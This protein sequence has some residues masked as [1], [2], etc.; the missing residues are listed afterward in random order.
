MNLE[1][2]QQS[3]DFLNIG[4]IVCLALA[5]LC[6]IITVILFVRFDVIRM[7]R[8]STGLAARRS[9]SQFNEENAT[10]T[11]K[12]NIKSGAL[13]VGVLSTSEVDLPPSGGVTTVLETP[14]EEGFAV[15]RETLI[16]HT[17]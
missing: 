11:D 15:V 13:P 2:M 12:L 7:L 5:A 8:E 6:L 17:D 3:L 1:Q 9:E 4:F 16:I 10:V 14:A